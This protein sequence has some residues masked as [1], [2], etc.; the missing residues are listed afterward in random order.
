MFEISIELDKEKNV[1]L[2]IPMTVLK[3]SRKR[4]LETNIKVNVGQKSK[5]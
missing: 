1:H 5:D 3:I 2:Y 4:N